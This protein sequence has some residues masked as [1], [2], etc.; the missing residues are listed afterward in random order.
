[1]VVSLNIIKYKILLNIIN[2]IGRADSSYNYENENL[3]VHQQI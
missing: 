3:H 2:C 1:M